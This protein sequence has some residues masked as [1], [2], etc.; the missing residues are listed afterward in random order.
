MKI[1]LYNL[2]TTIKIGGVESLVWDVAQRLAEREHD[3]TLFGGNGAVGRQLPNVKVL[4][5]PYIARETWGRVRPLRKSLN[6]LKLLERLSMAPAALP[7]LLRGNFDI[8]QVVKPYD[9]PIAARARA[10]S[11]ARFIYNSHGTDFFPGD[12]LFRRSIDGAFACSRYNAT[13]VEARYHIPIDVAY[14]GFDE[15]LFRPVPPDQALRARYSPDG[16]PVLL[17]V[18]RLVT[19]KGLDYLLD[20]V[21]MLNGRMQPQELSSNAN[22][23]RAIVPR[24][25]VRLILAGDGPHRAALQERANRL[26]LGGRVQFLGGVPHAEVPRLNAISDA[27]VVP[28]TDHE[29][30][31]I[32]ACEAMGCGRPVIATRVGGLPEVVRDGETG[33]LVPPGDAVALAERIAMLIGDAGLRRRMGVAARARAAMF[34]WD[35]VIERMLASYQQALAHP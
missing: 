17:Y 2:T 35:R 34:T 19:F 9:F 29:T 13:M 30:F 3:V 4:R 23:S 25:P 16:A 15:S 27:F 26:G 8:V 18:G 33:F 10:R 7:D 28:S 31:C 20:A 6:L 21:A 32:A 24:L 14:N 12:V 11:G 22:R 1:A 5:Y